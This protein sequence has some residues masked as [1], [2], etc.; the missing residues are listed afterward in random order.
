MPFGSKLVYKECFLILLFPLI[1]AED[2]KDPL[3]YQPSYVKATPAEETLLRK[4]VKKT[5]SADKNG[6]V[7]TRSVGENQL[8][9]R[10][11]STLKQ[12]KQG[13]RA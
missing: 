3:I 10:L 5:L 12:N 1:L 13:A 7:S 4:V 2:R 8:F 6:M 9:S 11:L